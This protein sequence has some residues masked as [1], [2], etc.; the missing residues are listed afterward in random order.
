MTD[1]EQLE[2]LCLKILKSGVP[3]EKC[4]GG[5]FIEEVLASVVNDVIPAIQA[6]MDK[7]D[8]SRDAREYAS[9]REYFNKGIV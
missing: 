6:D 2:S 5:F 9:D 7:E 8:H 1:L 3:D 4:L